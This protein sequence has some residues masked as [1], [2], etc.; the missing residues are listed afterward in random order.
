[1]TFMPIE[2]AELMWSCTE[3]EKQ[4]KSR[5]MCEEEKKKD[6]VKRG[7]GADQKGNTERKEKQQGRCLCGSKDDGEGEVLVAGGK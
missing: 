5:Q 7:G 3:R 6:A 1:M 4:G 2:F